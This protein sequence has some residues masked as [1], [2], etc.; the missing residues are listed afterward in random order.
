MQCSTAGQGLLKGAC[1]AFK[2]KFFVV[3]VCYRE[4][5]N[6]ISAAETR[7]KLGHEGQAGT[8]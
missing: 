1:L 5:L 6:N 7:R 2:A 3:L 4:F 8:L